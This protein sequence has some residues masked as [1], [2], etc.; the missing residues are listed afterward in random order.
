MSEEELN[1][2]QLDDEDLEKK[3]EL[4]IKRQIKRLEKEK[5]KELLLENL[6]EPQ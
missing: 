3:Q 6:K 1:I 4:A 5:P 2:I